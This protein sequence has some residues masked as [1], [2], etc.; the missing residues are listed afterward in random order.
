MVK[1]LYTINLI[2]TL[3]YLFLQVISLFALKNV[4]LLLENLLQN[5]VN[6]FYFEI[7]FIEDLNLFKII[8]LLYSKYLTL[9]NYLLLFIVFFIANFKYILILF[10]HHFRFKFFDFYFFTV[11][12]LG[13]FLLRKMNYYFYYYLIFLLCNSFC[14]NFALTYNYIL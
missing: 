13:Y 5:Y 2:I 6:S 8:H 11:H 10:S 3:L 4:H 9:L 12:F 1:I 7:L 14:S